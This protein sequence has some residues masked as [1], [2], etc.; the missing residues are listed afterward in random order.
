MAT[1]TLVVVV[2]TG[3]LGGDPEPP[4]SEAA[5]PRVTTAPATT[6]PATPWTPAPTPASTVTPSPSSTP[7]PTVV[8]VAAPVQLQVPSVGIDVGVLPIAPP[9]GGDLDP[10]TMRDAY[11]ID[12][13]G[14]PG[15]ETDNTVYI[16][17]H[18][19]DSGPAAFNSLFDTGAQDA[20]VHPGDEI[21]LTTGQ[22]RLTYVVSGSA[23]YPK[24]SLA[25]VDEVWRIVPD[26]LVL[27]TCFQRN[28][29]GASQDN[30]V[31][32]AELET[33]TTQS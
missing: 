30:L 23:R 20:K 12:A 8:A 27:I 18:S 11:W 32:Y 31:I 5:A 13:F 26:R 21:V 9:T 24:D 7:E 19:W 10:P 17:G 4:P 6:A 25:E 1:I 29:G 28:D 14:Q 16:A 33:S 2:A 3:L 15:T 22:G